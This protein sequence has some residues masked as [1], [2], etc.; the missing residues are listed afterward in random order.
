LLGVATTRK[1]TQSNPPGLIPCQFEFTVGDLPAT[2]EY[3]VV[4]RTLDRGWG[5]WSIATLQKR[6]WRVTVAITDLN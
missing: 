2:E 1:R 4:D 3:F 5:P 6:D